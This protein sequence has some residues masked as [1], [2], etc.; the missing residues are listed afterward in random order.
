MT[1]VAMSSNPGVSAPAASARTQSTTDH[2]LLARLTGFFFLVTYAASIPPVAIF[3]VP[4]LS[5]PAFVLGGGFD[6]NL[7]WGAVLELVLILANIAT[8]LTLYPILRKRHA[9]L[10]LGFVAA[11]L[12]E[13]AFIGVGIV[14][15][16]ALNTLRLTA[17]AADPAIADGRR[18]GAGRHP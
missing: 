5:D 11:R 9:V 4:A 6:M 12:T 17:G 2:Q 10:S 3:Y 16:L 18:P 1:T 14:A 8:A 13:S 7:S 15:I